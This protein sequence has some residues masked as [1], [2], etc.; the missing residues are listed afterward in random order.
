MAVCCC[1]HRDNAP[2]IDDILSDLQP[3]REQRI[4]PRVI[5][6]VQLIV[7]ASLV[8]L[9]CV[10][11]YYMTHKLP[12]DAA[13]KLHTHSCRSLEVYPRLAAAC[14]LPWLASPLVF[15]PLAVIPA[16]LCLLLC[17]C[18]FSYPSP[19]SV[20]LKQ[21]SVAPTR[22]PR[23]AAILALWTGMAAYQAFNISRS[24]SRIY[25]V[26]K[27]PSPSLLVSLYALCVHRFPLP[28]TLTLAPH[29]LAAACCSCSSHRRSR[30]PASSSA[31][32]VCA[33]AASRCE[34]SPMSRTCPIMGPLSDIMTRSGTCC[35]R[36]LGP[37]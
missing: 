35:W 8:L 10:S 28:F 11:V 31:S 17:A 34:D 20:P 25:S 3:V 18:L 4:W 32:S 5:A 19:F 14:N 27:L 21:A 6:A 26:R 2:L 37:A 1:L 23:M 24:T 15:V 12:L 13:V 33:R 22:W 30:S 16:A 29:S 7:A 36:G 9:G